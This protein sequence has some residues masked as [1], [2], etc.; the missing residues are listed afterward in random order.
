MPTATLDHLADQ[1]FTRV[2]GAPLVERNAVRLL[3]DGAGNYPAWL[4][5]IGRATRWIHFE[6]Y[7][8]HD[9]EVGERFASALSARAGAGVAVRVIYDWVGG[10]GT[11]RRF[12]RRMRAA[13]IDV[14]SFNPPGPGSPLGWVSRDH[15]KMLAV[16][17][18]VAFVAGLCVGRMWAGDPERG[19]EP[20]RDTGIEIRGP[21]VAEVERAFAGSWARCGPALPEDEASSGPPAPAGEVALRVVATVPSRAPVFRLDQLIAAAARSSLWLTDAYFAGTAAYVDALRAAARDGVD[22]RLLVPGGSDIPWLRPVTQAGY[23]A[24]LEA[25]VRVFEWN[26]SMLHAKTAVADRRWARVGSTNLNLA[27][28]VGNYELDVAIEDEVFA[29]L[30]E[31][32]Y[33]DD[34]G[35]ATEVVLS[36][37]RIR[38]EP[39]PLRPARVRASGGSASRAAAGALRVGNALGAA[40]TRR[41]VLGRSESGALLLVGLTLCVLAAIGAVWPRALAVPLVVLAAWQGIALL[42]RGARTR[43]SRPFT[44]RRR[45]GTAGAR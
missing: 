17:G 25:G 45:A 20:W 30:M 31:A 8:I 12:W 38:R 32:M 1:A 2:A 36:R 34:L 9:D 44:R 42:V 33:V 43:W 27:S 41:R 39:L 11:S 4:E 18:E 29:S 10:F 13:G 14:R 19:V 26:G 28:W 22:V 40:L 37:R 16:D 7:V 5:A 3:R 24:L 21:A 35:H 6:C 15:R 23:R